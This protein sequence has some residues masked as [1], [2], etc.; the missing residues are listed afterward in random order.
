MFRMVRSNRKGFTLIELLVTIS[1]IGILSTLAVMSTIRARA[2]AQHN[3][4]LGD[5]KQIRT[6]ITLLESDTGKWPN[7]CKPNSVANPEVMVTGPQAGL[8]AS[9]TVGDQGDGCFWSAKDVQNWAGPYL[10]VNKDP[11]NHDYWFDPDYIPYQNCASKTAL[12]QTVVVESAGPDG[13]ALNSY[14]CDDVFLQIK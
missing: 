2:L 10:N 11:W 5:L 9:P 7:G 8:V 14:D 12:P 13:S 4:A 1:I 3:K 6:A